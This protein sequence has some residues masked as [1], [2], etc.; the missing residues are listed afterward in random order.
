ME[1]TAVISSTIAVLL[2]IIGMVA[3]PFT[4]KAVMSMYRDT[5]KAPTEK[6]RKEIRRVCFSLTIPFIV[7]SFASGTFAYLIT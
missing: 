2:F 1:T 3:G 7:M 5:D 6:E 4:Y